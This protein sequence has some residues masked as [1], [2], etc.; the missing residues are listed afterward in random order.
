[1]KRTV[2]RLTA[3]ALLFSLLPVWG[4]AAEGNERPLGTITGF[5]NYEAP[6]GAEYFAVIGITDGGEEFLLK[7]TDPENW[8]V[9][10]NY[11]Q[12]SIVKGRDPNVVKEFYTMEDLIVTAVEYYVSL[13]GEEDVLYVGRLTP[14]ARFYYE[15]VGDGVALIF[16]LE[17]F[18]VFVEEE[19]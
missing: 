16:D 17:H 4:M 9:G 19:E 7:G 15:M 3:L 14:D 2:M 12:A 10:A 5:G 8:I 18:P 1:M 6:D 11:V 13:E